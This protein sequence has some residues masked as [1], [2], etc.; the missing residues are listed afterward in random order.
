[1]CG[2][3]GF[4]QLHSQSAD[5]AELIRRMTSPL[6]PRGPDGEGFHVA[7]GIALG[8]R[9]LSIIDLAGGA[10]PM[11]S[12]DKRYHIVY[13]GEVYNYVELRAELE[14]RGCVFHTQSDTEVLP[15]QFVLD[16]VDALQLC[17][18][19]FAVA[20]WDRDEERLFLARVASASSRSTTASAT[21]N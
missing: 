21:A 18:G 2:I 6:T 20:I 13:N 17:N 3:A 15:N 14:Q 12:N 5:V 7:P 8:H 19:M 1:M 4:T 11:R 10:Q 16:G 9:R